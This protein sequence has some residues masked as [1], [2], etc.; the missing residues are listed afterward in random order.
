M[1]QGKTI[2]EYD[3]ESPAALAV[4]RLWENVADAL[5]NLTR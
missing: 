5:H 2:I 1:V 4:K 3:E